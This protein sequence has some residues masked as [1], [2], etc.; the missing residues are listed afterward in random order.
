[1]L[2][3]P[4][5]D[6]NAAKKADGAQKCGLPLLP[7]ISATRSIVGVAIRPLNLTVTEWTESRNWTESTE[8]Y[9]AKRSAQANFSHQR[10][11]AG[12]GWRPSCAEWVNSDGLAVCYVG[13]PPNLL[14]VICR[15]Q[16]LR[17]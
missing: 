10:S 2:T 7:Q 16:R 17:Q 14:I 12:Q 3:P 13:L 5:P 8:T 15:R 4:L 1:M 11:E 6:H 9:E